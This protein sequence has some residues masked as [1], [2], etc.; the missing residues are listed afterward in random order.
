MHSVHKDR[1]HK[2][3]SMSNYPIHS[4]CQMDNLD[5]FHILVLKVEKR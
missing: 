2:D 4:I 3:L 1:V 5:L